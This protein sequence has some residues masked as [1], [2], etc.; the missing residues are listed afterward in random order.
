M[1]ADG[2][3]PGANHLGANG[4]GLLVLR[5]LD[6]DPR[7]D[8]PFFERDRLA[9]QRK[10]AALDHDGHGF[11]AADDDLPGPRLVCL[12]NLRNRNIDAPSGIRAV[13][14][15]AA[16][17]L[18]SKC[19]RQRRFVQMAGVGL[20]ARAVAEVDFSL[21]KKTGALAYLVS[22]L[23][24]FHRQPC[25]TAK[26][27]NGVVHGQWMCVG[28]G[29]FYGGPLSLFPRARFDDGLLDLCVFPRVT[30]GLVLE[31]AMAMAMNRMETWHGARHLRLSEL[32]IEGPPGTPVQ[33]DGDPA[34]ALPVSFSILP[35][36]LK[37][38]VP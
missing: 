24:A 33:M 12:R 17:Q 8:R 31:A 26:W 20:D 36:A 29:Q 11:A 4:L 18:E 23:K 10:A 27:A 38:L 5:G 3:L 6:L 30:P 28:N 37:V 16:V 22:G 1:Q 21:K 2:N 32:S 34:G 15:P 7:S 19:P 25:L 14:L 35:R 9:R 13:D